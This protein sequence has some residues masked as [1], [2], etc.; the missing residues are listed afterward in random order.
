MAFKKLKDMSTLEK[1]VDVTDVVKLYGG[2]IW[3][4]KYN[5]WLDKSNT[6]ASGF[7]GK[8][9][10]VSFWISVLLSFAGFAFWIFE[11][12]THAL[13]NSPFVLVGLT[14]LIFTTAI[15]LLRHKYYGLFKLLWLFPIV[16]WA[17]IFAVFGFGILSEISP[18]LYNKIW[19]L[20]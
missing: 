10:R 7:V 14:P 4:D 11:L 9:L 17:F 16:L 3:G 12:N 5:E 6:K 8:F 19:D 20:I 2:G 15:Q 18:E 13:K 1:L